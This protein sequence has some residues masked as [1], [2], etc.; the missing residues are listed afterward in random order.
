MHCCASLCHVM[1][2]REARLDVCVSRPF[3]LS[4]SASQRTGFSGKVMFK[5]PKSELCITECETTLVMPSDL[6]MLKGSSFTHSKPVWLSFFCWTQKMIFSRTDQT[7]LV[8]IDFYCM[9][10]KY[11]DVSRNILNVPQKKRK[12]WVNDRIFIFEWMMHLYSALLCI[13]VHPKRFTIM[14]GGISSTTTSDFRS[15]YP[16][17]N[18]SSFSQTHNYKI[19]QDVV[20]C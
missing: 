12:S 4:F 2:L 14:W 15:S 1:S 18:K 7:V 20:A 17:K 13:A 3:S 16:F 9:V 10:K 8:T 11:W 5:T 6:G 19:C